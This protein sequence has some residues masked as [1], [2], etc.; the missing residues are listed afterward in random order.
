LEFLL[1]FVLLFSVFLLDVFHLSLIEPS[2]Q[3]NLEIRQ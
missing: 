3:R 1:S 2:E